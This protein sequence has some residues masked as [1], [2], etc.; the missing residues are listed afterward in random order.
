MKSNKNL[1]FIMN[2]TINNSVYS[3]LFQ[4]GQKAKFALSLSYFI[5]TQ[6]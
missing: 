4:K 3:K 5:D 6:D 2:M 1:N